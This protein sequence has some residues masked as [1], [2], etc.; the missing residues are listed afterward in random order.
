MEPDKPAKPQQQQTQQTTQLP[1]WVNDASQQNYAFRATSRRQAPAAISGANGAGCLG[2]ACSKAGI[3]L[4]TATN[5][6]LPQ[7]NAATAGF[8][9]RARP[10]FRCRFPPADLQCKSAIPA[11]QRQDV[12]AGQLSN[13][14][15]RAVH[16]PVHTK[17]DQRIAADHA[18]AAR[19]DAVQQRFGNAVNHTGAHSAAQDLAFNKARRKPKARSAKRRWP[20][21]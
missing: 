12:T 1:P 17:R 7:Y 4:A 13:T 21:S 10:D 18:T 2:P 15:S 5:A 19:A 3:P 9:R 16:G 11:T 20:R 6:G 14:E 8:F